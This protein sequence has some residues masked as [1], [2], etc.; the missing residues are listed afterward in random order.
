[1]TGAADISPRLD[2]RLPGFNAV[3]RPGADELAV[4]LVAALPLFT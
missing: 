3:A 4:H 2:A 1:M